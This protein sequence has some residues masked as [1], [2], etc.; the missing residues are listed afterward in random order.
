MVIRTFV[1]V[2]TTE[3][4]LFVSLIFEQNQHNVYREVLIAGDLSKEDMDQASSL[5]AENWV[6]RG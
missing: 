1:H 3:P 6:R 5:V 4:L 2:C